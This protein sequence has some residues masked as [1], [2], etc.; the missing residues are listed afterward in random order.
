MEAQISG[1]VT[2][3]G[4]LLHPFNNSKSI[5]KVRSLYAASGI[6]RSIVFG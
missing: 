5:Q 1:S 4:Y 3:Y 2:W 6:F